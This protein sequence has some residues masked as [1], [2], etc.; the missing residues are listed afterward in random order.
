M[1][2][3]EQLK[4]EHNAVR[5][6]LRI[7][8][9]ICKRIEAGQRV[10]VSHLEELADFFHTFVDKCHHAKEEEMLFV[11]IKDSLDPSDG[12]RIGALIK[13]HVTGRNFVRDLSYAISDYKAGDAR[14]ARD[15][16]RYARTY[17]TLL[18]QHIDIEDN[19]LYPIADRRLTEK[20]QE[21]LFRDFERLEEE[22]VGHG[23]HQEFHQMVNKLKALYLE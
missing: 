10:E 3:T 20:K 15:V 5:V 21:E 8:D 9:Q 14:A 23:K 11:A 18:N 4:N 1:K 19:V 7:L 2:A 17:M 16:V 13:D 12:D 6:T 22:E